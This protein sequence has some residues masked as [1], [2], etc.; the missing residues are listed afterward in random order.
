M[1]LNTGGTFSEFVSNIMITD[2]AIRAHKETKRGR[3]WLL[4][5]VVLPLSTGRCTTTAPPI[6]LDSYNST[7]ISVCNNSGL[8]DHLNPSTSGQRLRLYLHPRL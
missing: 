7:S 6:N 4:C 5:L 3:L 2:D 8:P 1:A